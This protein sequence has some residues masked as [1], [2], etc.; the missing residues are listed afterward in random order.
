MRFSIATCAKHLP[1]MYVALILLSGCNGLS[2]QQASS[3]AGGPQTYM[4]LTV[5]DTK[6]KL[7]LGALTN[8]LATYTIDDT[9]DTFTQT[10]TSLGAGGTLVDDSGTF[11]M[12]NRGLLSL[13]TTYSLLGPSGATDQNPTIYGSYALELP[14]QGG[15]FVQILGNPVVPLAATSSCPDLG[16]PQTF[17]FITLPSYDWN[18][19]TETAFGSV[20]ISTSGS[21]TVNLSNIQQSTLSG[22]SISLPASTTT[23]ACS[24]TPYGNTVSVPGIVMVTDPTTNTTNTSAATLGIGASGMLVEDNAHTSTS[25]NNLLGAGTGAIGI[26]Q[27]TTALSMGT[28]TGA[29]YLGFLFSPNSSTAVSPEAAW[30]STLVSFGSSSTAPAGCPTPIAPIYGGDF[31]SNNPSSGNSNSDLQIDLGVPSATSNGLYPNVTVCI[32]SS[33]I[34]NPQ[35]KTYSFS[36]VAIVGQVEG[37]YVILL[38]GDDGSSAWSLY[39]MQSS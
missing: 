15:G 17:Q 20:T 5:P 7:T 3:T 27:P 36:A 37:K 4:A 14:N 32:G 38:I 9:N 18:P 39:L 34:A 30:T 31:P 24:P 35:N 22:T 8:T 16:T 6:G 33:F 21:T 13:G 25:I 2:L 11:Q 26:P 19:K 12:L 10:S 1:A 28:V 29:Q 23:G